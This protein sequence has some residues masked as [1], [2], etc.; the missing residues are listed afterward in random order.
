MWSVCN[1]FFSSMDSGTKPQSWRGSWRL[2]QTNIWI[3]IIDGLVP[4][5]LE[6]QSWHWLAMPGLPSP[7]KKICQRLIVFLLEFPHL[8][9]DVSPR[10]LWK[11][12][13]FHTH[14]REQTACI[15]N[16]NYESVVWL[17]FQSWRHK[18][19]AVMRLLYIDSTALLTVNMPFTH[20]V[21]VCL[22]KCRHVIFIQCW[23]CSGSPFTGTP[24]V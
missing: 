5:S 3:P 15:T 19:W 12:P 23:I 22:D 9:T 10:D 1:S 14:Y 20:E 18:T 13:V 6:P 8:K 16:S 11:C 21:N 4:S 2:L 7:S 17:Q 24:V